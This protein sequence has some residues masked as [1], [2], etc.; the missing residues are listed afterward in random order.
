MSAHAYPQRVALIFHNTA[1]T[2]AQLA[3]SAAQA[4]AHL[5]A[6][7]V[8]RGTRVALLSHNSPA[9]VTAVHA[10]TQ[11]GAVLVPLNT[12]LTL[13]ELRYQVTLAQPRLLLVS[14][15]YAKLSDALDLPTLPLDTLMQPHP[16]RVPTQ[17]LNLDALHTLVFTSGT[18]GRP[19]AAAL[20]LSA[21]FY[22]ATAS[23]LRLGV[24]ADDRWLC[25]LPLFHVGGLAILLRSA[26]YG[27]GVVLMERFDLEAVRHAIDAQAVTL[28]SL[29]P[30]ML[31]RL[32]DAGLRGTNHL[33]LA[34]L[35]GAAATESLVQRAQA[36]GIPVATTYGLSEACSQVATQTPDRMA[37]KPGS[38][39]RPLPFIQVRVVDEHGA[40][41]PPGAYG[42]VIVSGPTLMQGY[43]DNPDATAHTLRDDWL[44]T[45]DIGTLDADGDLWLIQRRSDLIVS[46]G[47]NVYPAEVEAALRRHPAVADVCV[48]G[49]DDPEWG[50]QVAAA[51]VCQPG[52]AIADADLIAHARA[53]LAGYKVP[54]RL[55]FVEALPLTGSDKVSRAA[56]RA[57]FD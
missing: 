27:T 40:D 20:T 3:D 57:L 52:Q 9:Y 42:E 12:R 50:Q 15:D 46:G 30:T 56:V 24:Q 29:V 53:H 2:Y 41:L 48:V 19:K 39:G 25:V 33:R 16:N 43:L 44:H 35:G 55:R 23:A 38:V 21:H 45:G 22:S 11:L 7:G 18:T 34:L 1:W 8:E 13:D 36:V 28:A 14:S 10:L 37:H 4:R 49:V 26:L 5:L 47:E 17:P 6:T 31:T 51:V 54:R 32:L